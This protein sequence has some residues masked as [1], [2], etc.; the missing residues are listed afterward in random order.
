MGTPIS[1]QF[2][3]KRIRA[4]GRQVSMVWINLRRP[5]QLYYPNTLVKK[6]NSIEYRSVQDLRAIHNERHT[7]WDLTPTFSRRQHL[8]KI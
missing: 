3:S 7:Q 1:R 4:I 6:L 2:C 5:V 8:R